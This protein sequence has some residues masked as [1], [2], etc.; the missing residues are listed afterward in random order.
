MS[1]QLIA[2]AIMAAFYAIY[3]VKLVQ[4]RK[5]G[6]KTFMISPDSL[7]D[8]NKVLEL[9][10]LAAVILTSAA[11]LASIALSDYLGGMPFILIRI[12]GVILG[13]LS[14]AVFWLST[15]AM[16]KNWRVGINHN[17]DTKLVTKGI[18]SY[19]RNP[20]FLAF[21]MLFAGILMMFYNPV[22]LMCSLFS[23]VLLHIQIMLE[24][25]SLK[26]T[27]GDEYIEYKKKV[28]RYFGRIKDAE[29]A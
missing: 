6:I 17:G 1:F 26:K 21:D 11:E 10:M 27:F 23:A 9:I 15:R 3:I 18:Y 28:R 2:V 14:V 8:T 19:S 13:I 7:R 12:A 24:E 5:E 4:Q 25:R 16:R 22:L 29:K 20:A